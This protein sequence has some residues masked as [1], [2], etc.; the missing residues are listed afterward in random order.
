[1]TSFTHERTV[2]APAEAFFDVI[3]DHVGYTELT[4]IRRAEMERE[5]TPSPN[6]LGAIRSLSLVGPPMREEVIGYERPTSFSYKLL[7]GLPVRDH[8]GTV[9]IEPQGERCH[10]T[11]SVETTPTLP[12]GGITVVPILR[13]SIGRLLAGAAKEAEKRAAAEPAAAVV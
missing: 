4:P 3:T 11:Y 10:V 8:V 9:T 7:S 6:G 12:F 2:N 5:G 1:M 13:I